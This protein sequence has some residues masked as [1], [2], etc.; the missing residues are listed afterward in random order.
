MEFVKK[1]TIPAACDI[2]WERVISPEGINY[3]LWPVMQMTVPLHMRNKTLHDIPLGEKICRSW[4]LL[5]GFLPFDYDDIVIADRE[6][7]HCFRETSTMLSI[8]RWE[9]ERTVNPRPDGCELV[10]RVSF[11]LR[12][13][14][15]MIPGMENLV[16]GILRWLFEHRHRRLAKWFKTHADDK[17]QGL[18][19]HELTKEETRDTISK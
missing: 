2:V 7:G 3:E 18:Y 14:S 10:D 12:R 13:L 19:E 4:F 17:S 8:K 16:A 11:D 9:H 15:A 6:P 5:F 1:S